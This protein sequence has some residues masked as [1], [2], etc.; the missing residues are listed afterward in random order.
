MN[1]A[2]NNL[3]LETKVHPIRHPKDRNHREGQVAL[4][5]L[6]HYAKHCNIMYDM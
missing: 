5:H 3:E 4:S 6:R 1:E 2:V